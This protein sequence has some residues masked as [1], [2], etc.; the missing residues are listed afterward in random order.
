MRGQGSQC[1]II[2][3][4]PRRISATSLASRVSQEIGESPKDKRTNLCGHQIRF[5]SR[6]SATTRMLY[7]TTGVVLRQLQSDKDLSNV[8]H[9]II[10]EVGL[11]W[12]CASVDE[13]YR[14]ASLIPAPSPPRTCPPPPPPPYSP[15][16]PLPPPPPPPPP[17]TSD[18]V[19][20]SF[21]NF[22]SKLPGGSGEQFKHQDPLL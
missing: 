18:F 17:P 19:F 7:C 20:L 4:E 2:V 11:D 21:V 13:F 15:P 1:N 16:P 14:V 10:D 8:S 5:E 9:L 3:T 6:K 22:N 12:L